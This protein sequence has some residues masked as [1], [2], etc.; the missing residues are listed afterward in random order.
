MPRAPS[1]QPQ[2]APSALPSA[3]LTAVASPDV[4]GAGAA[5]AI[6]RAAANIYER[7]S[8]EADQVAFMEAD[9]KAA[10]AQT[11]IQLQVR[12]LQGKDAAGAPD[13][14]RQKW[15]QAMGEIQPTLTGP[16]QQRAFARVAAGRWEELYKTT[17]FHVAEQT[18]KYAD[19]TTESSIKASTDEA[20][21]NAAFPDSIEAAKRRQVAV[22]HE[23]AGR[24]G[25]PL[26]GPVYQEQE[27]KV[28]SN[29][30][31][32]V[33]KGLLYAGND[34]TASAFYQAHVTEFVAADR[35]HIEA[36]LK[37]G[38]TRG[39]ALRRTNAI[40]GMAGADYKAALAEVT[41]ITDPKVEELA[42]EMVHKR[43]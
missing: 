32:E 37:E 17:Q 22:L 2:V 19:Q 30:N 35:D 29:T 3:R 16:R 12:D 23:W 11:D 28:L 43:L 4:Y 10:K 34:I 26:D 33:V 24:K 41:K 25:L 36:A 5:D 14:A 38:S 15:E 31:A 6:T 42:R 1:S 27:A 9:T 18:T 40:M 8:L 21:L 13:V 7:Y 20:R 39:E